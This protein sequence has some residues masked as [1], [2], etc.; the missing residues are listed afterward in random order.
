MY[1]VMAIVRDGITDHCRRAV[2]SLRI[3]R[4]C[5]DHVSESDEKFENSKSEY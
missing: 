5:I 2:C 4:G 3:E 1:D